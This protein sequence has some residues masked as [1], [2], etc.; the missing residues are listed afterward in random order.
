MRLRQSKLHTR[1]PTN[2]NYPKQKTLTIHKPPYQPPSRHTATRFLQHCPRSQ[3]LML[4]CLVALL[5]HAALPHWL[6]CFIGSHPITNTSNTPMHPF[7]TTSVW[8]PKLSMRFGNPQIMGI[9]ADLIPAPPFALGN[10]PGFAPNILRHAIQTTQPNNIFISYR[11]LSEI[12]KWSDTSKEV[13]R[14]G[15]GQQFLV[16]HNS[17]TINYDEESGK[18]VVQYHTSSC[19]VG[20][21]A[22]MRL[23]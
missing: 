8:E 11:R 9:A 23:V 12:T 20:C 17:P 5:A 2:A 6:H 7:R 10:P 3:R 1:K 22:S 19:D 18:V 14:I 13:T 4:L 16:E 15:S 21:R